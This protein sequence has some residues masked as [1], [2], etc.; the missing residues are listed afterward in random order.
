[1]TKQVAIDAGT[2]DADW[3]SLYKVS[4]VAALLA[5]MIFR[6]NIAAEISL[7][8]G[9]KAPGTV[10]D[11]FALLQSNRFLGLSYLNIFDIV[12]YFLISLMFLALFIALRRISKSYMAVAAVLAFL[13]IAVYWATN[14]AFSMLSL[15]DQYAAAT[16][17][18]QRTQL[19]AAGQAML[20]INRFSGPHA[21]PGT[22]GYMSLLLIAGAGLITSIV[23][24]DSNLFNRAT[25]YVG[26]LAS[27]LDLAYCTFVL[28]PAV[29]SGVLALSFVPVAGLFW[30]IW[31]IMVGW[32]LYK[33][34]T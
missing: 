27:A 34:G 23:M 18:A 28:I 9:A 29:D 2:L 30:M 10:R 5:G 22:G 33:L 17:D 21:H 11:W 7:F 19:L 1:M 26:I 12:N 20:A 8:S 14:T 13:G 15:S 3:K 24:L 6:R 31:H 16:T 4:G 32:K 25:A